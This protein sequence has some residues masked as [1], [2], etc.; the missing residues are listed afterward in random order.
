MT[1]FLG[2]VEGDL[3]QTL[4]CHLRLPVL[5]TLQLWPQS[6]GCT[7]NRYGEP[8]KTATWSFLTANADLHTAFA[9]PKTAFADVSVW[10]VVDGGGAGPGQRRPPVRGGVPEVP[11]AGEEALGDPHG[12]HVQ[13]L[14]E[15][16]GADVPTVACQQLSGEEKEG[17][18]TVWATPFLVTFKKR[19]DHTSDP[20]PPRVRSVVSRPL[21]SSNFDEKS[22][23]CFSTLF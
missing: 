6:R 9:D 21:H 17:T 19:T 2:V 18:W 20:P 1:C 13:K 12:G 8:P 15:Q 4:S 7:P 10:R 11:R 3:V 22:L 23:K 16:R 5:K 14:V